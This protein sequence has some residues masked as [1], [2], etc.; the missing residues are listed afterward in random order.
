MYY[1]P[2]ISGAD[3]G[4]LSSF[5]TVE[6]RISCSHWYLYRYPVLS[7]GVLP[8][9]RRL[10]TLSMKSQSWTGASVTSVVTIGD[11]C[12]VTGRTPQGTVC[13]WPRVAPRRR[14]GPH[15]PR[16][17]MPCGALPDRMVSR[18]ER[19]T[20]WLLNWVLGSARSCV[21]APR[22]CAACGRG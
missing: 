22:L 4:A 2:C 11:R 6:Y 20:S 3:D 9:S 17:C 16:R 15:A 21:F 7:L 8:L 13:H 5:I 1:N 18:T 19:K 10:A 14:Y 12:Y